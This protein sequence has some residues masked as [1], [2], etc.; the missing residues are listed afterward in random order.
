MILF[1]KNPKLK[2]K[3]FFLFFFWGGG[4]GGVAGRTD[5]NQFA[6]YPPQG[7]QL[8]KIILKSMHKCTCYGPDELNI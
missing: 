1:T 8:C 7:C 2:K 5:P 4:G 6:N 3:I